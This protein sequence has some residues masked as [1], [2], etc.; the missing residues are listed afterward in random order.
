MQRCIVNHVV[1][2]FEP[3]L[4]AKGQAYVALSHVRS[5][6]RW[7]KVEL[8]CSKLTGKTPYNEN[9]MKEMKRGN[10]RLKE[11]DARIFRNCQGDCIGLSG[12]QLYTDSCGVCHSGTSP[13]LDCTNSC[14]LPSK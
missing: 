9:A 14:Y 10:S 7:R 1:V 11:K 3:A 13:F 12:D 2:Y 6:D 4:F 5:L 8:D